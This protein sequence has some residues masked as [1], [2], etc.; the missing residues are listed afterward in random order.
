M[1]KYLLL[2]LTDTQVVKVLSGFSLESVQSGEYLRITQSKFEGATKALAVFRGH[3]LGEYTI[4]PDVIVDSK[5]GKSKF[6]LEPISVTDYV[7]QKIHYPTSNRAS[8]VTIEKLEN[9]I[10]KGENQ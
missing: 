4:A 6:L 5:T 1:N 8:V 2:K 3:I 7:G 9:I 10:L